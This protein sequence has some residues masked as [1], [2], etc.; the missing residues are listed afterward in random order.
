MILFTA[1]L[2]KF[3]QQGEKTGWTY[4]VVLLLWPSN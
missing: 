3:G 4:I 1:T 2:E